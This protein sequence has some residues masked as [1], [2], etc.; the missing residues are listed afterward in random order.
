MRPKKLILV[1]D[2]DPTSLGITM[3]SLSV[4]GY[5][6]VG[7]HTVAQAR[8]IIAENPVDTILWIPCV[9]YHNLIEEFTIPSVMKSMKPELRGMDRILEFLR[10]ACA[11]KRGPK[12]GT[13][14]PQK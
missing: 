1:L 2:P 14:R 7:A 4:N 5:R 10:L 3:F 8:S 11:K 13:R 12:P 9:E 6:T